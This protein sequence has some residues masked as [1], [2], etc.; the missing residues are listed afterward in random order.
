[1]GIILNNISRAF[2]DVDTLDLEQLKD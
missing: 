2:D 1:M